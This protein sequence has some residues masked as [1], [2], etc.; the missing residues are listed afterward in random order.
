MRI[1]KR[2]ACGR[3]YTLDQFRALPFSGVWHLNDGEEPSKL[4]QRDCP[5]GSSITIGID[6]NGNFYGGPT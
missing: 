4:E 1:V 2:C 3:Q 6:R 5:C